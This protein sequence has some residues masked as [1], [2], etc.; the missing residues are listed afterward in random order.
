[1]KCL[2]WNCRG[3]G[4]PKFFRAISNYVNMYNPACIAVLETKCA[5]SSANSLFTRLGYNNTL[6][7]EGQ[8]RAGGIWIGWKPN[9]INVT[10]HLLHQNYINLEIDYNRKKMVFNHCLC[11]STTCLAGSKLG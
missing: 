5:A 2:V 11:L 6:I 1:M 10:G 7:Q 4:N 9:L 8:G 3:A